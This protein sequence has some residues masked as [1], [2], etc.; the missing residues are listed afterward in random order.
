MSATSPALRE[1]VEAHDDV[2]AVT[3]ADIFA[4]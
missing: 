4:I 2:L 1:A 3:A